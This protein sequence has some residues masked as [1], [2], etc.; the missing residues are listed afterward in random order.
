MRSACPAGDELHLAQLLEEGVVL[1]EA[2]F[3]LLEHRHRLLLADLLHELLEAV[4]AAVLRKRGSAKETVS[5]LSCESIALMGESFHRCHVQHDIFAVKGNVKRLLYD[6]NTS[7]P[8]NFDVSKAFIFI[9]INMNKRDVHNFYLR[10]DN[11]FLLKVFK[12]FFLN[13]SSYMLRKVI[14]AHSPTTSNQNTTSNCHYY[15]L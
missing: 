8:T 5:D 9:T 1:L 6:K 3:G 15:C 12:H 10:I 11:S 2:L 7:I 4:L 13:H 14:S